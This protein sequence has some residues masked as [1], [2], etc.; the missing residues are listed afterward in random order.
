MCTHKQASNHSK[1]DWV[2]NCLHFA[3]PPPSIPRGTVYYQRAEEPGCAN[4]RKHLSL[5]LFPFCNIVLLVGGGTPQQ[6]R[7]H[8]F[9]S[10]I[11][12]SSVEHL[13]I[14]CNRSCW[15][16]L[17]YGRTTWHQRHL[18]LP[19]Q[20]LPCKWVS[21]VVIRTWRPSGFKLGS[22]KWVHLLEVSTHGMRRGKN[23]LVRFLRGK[24]KTENHHHVDVQEDS[25]VVSI[26]IL[27]NEED[28]CNVSN[29]C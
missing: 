24:R 25:A 2:R 17:L 1:T 13:I 20:H 9:W 7:D 22:S 10:L 5:L 8:C 12:R 23:F 14:P 19:C 21:Y 3:S 29:M 6:S 4:G 27:L 28:T 26:A 18:H 16:L 15:P 11:G